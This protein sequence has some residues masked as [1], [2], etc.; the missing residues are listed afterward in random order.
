MKQAFGQFQPWIHPNAMCVFNHV[1]AAWIDHCSGDSKLAN[2]MIGP[3][4][5]P[6]SQQTQPTFSSQM[7]DHKRCK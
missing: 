1:H 7:E 4:P 2:T 6:Q 3:P 5:R